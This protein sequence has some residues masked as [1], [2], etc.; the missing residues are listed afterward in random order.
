MTDYVTDFICT[1]NFINEPEESE[2]LFRTQLLQAFTPKYFEDG[3]ERSIDDVFDEINN[4]TSN[5]YEKYSADNMIR[6]L[7][8]KFHNESVE[9]KFQMCFSYSTFYIMHRI[10]CGIINNNLDEKICN[11]LIDK[12]DNLDLVL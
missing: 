4:I 1:Y 7:M 11:N 12:I 3:N 10:L 9:V 5:L 6:K 8:N 2:M